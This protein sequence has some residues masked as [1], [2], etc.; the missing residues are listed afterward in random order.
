MSTAEIKRTLEQMTADERFFAA[1]YL[2]VLM[3]R[4]DPEYGVM[5][6]ERMGRMDMGKKVSLEEALRAHGALEAKGL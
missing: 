6:A 5:L 2:T 3:H 4:D 1:S